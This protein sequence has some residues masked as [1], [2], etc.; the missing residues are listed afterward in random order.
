MEPHPLT[1]RL[2]ARLAE[3]GGEPATTVIIDDI[4]LAVVDGSLEVGERL[5]T[6][7]ELAVVL[8]ISP[9][10]VEHAYQELERRGVVATRP[11]EGTF[12]S[13]TRPSEAELSRRREL[14]A[15]C[16]ETVERARAL[17]FDLDEL[18]EA[19]AEHRGA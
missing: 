4:W 3:G 6:A 10:A 13:L 17:G 7:R 18:W 12:V 2:A 16:R 14:A 11:G 15:L 9:R 5:P 1:Q 8:R 19:L